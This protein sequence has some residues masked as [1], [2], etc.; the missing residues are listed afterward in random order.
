[1][2][3]RINPTNDRR[4]YG[5]SQNGGCRGF[6]DGTPSFNM[7]IPR[8]R[9]NW[10]APIEFSADPRIMFGASEFVYRMNTD[11]GQ[12]TWCGSAPTSLR[13]PSLAPPASGT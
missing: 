9:D 8:N 7:R 4:Y 11:V 3:N 6:E 12:R 10:V 2:M 5:C 13:A 1:M